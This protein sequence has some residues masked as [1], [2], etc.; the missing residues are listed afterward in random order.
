[1]S[2]WLPVEN[3]HEMNNLEKCVGLEGKGGWAGWQ[4]V[5]KAKATRGLS[6]RQVMWY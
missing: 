4:K 1:M 3:N 6:L 5:D 2:L